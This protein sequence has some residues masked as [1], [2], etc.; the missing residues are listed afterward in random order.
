MDASHHYWIQILGHY[1]PQINGQTYFTKVITLIWQAVLQVWKLQNDHL[2]P[3]SPEQEDCS[4]LKAAVNKIF[5]EAQWDPQLQVLVEHLDPEQIM[6]CPTCNIWQWVTHSNNHMHKHQKV[7]KL[8]ACLCTKDI[9]QY[10]PRCNLWP[11]CTSTDKNL[12]HPP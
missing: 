3:G 1:H 2:H 8:Q 10:F 11:T 9:C 6:S 12:L 4:Y 5:F 7:Q